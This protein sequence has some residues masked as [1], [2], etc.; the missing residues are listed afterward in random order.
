VSHE[1]TAT[2]SRLLSHRVLAGLE[3]IAGP[4]EDLYRDLHSHPELSNQE[5]RTAA[6]AAEQLRRAG[7]DVT[8]GVG[9]TDPDLYQRAQQVGRIAEHVPTNHSSKFAPVVHPTLETGVQTLTTATFS[10]LGR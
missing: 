9:G 6:K 3:K 2:T 10:Y 1:P 7:Y 5:Q 8:D 4:L